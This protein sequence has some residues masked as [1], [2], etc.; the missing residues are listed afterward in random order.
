MRLSSDLCGPKPKRRWFLHKGH[1]FH[2]PGSFLDNLAAGVH[3]WNMSQNVSPD[4]T[5]DER[6][7]AKSARIA[8]KLGPGG[9]Y[10]NARAAGMSKAEATEKFPLQK[11]HKPHRL[12]PAVSLSDEVQAAR[13]AGKS[14]E[15]IHA[16]ACKLFPVEMKVEAQIE[17]GE[18]DDLTGRA[19]KDVITEI[20][21]RQLWKT[22]RRPAEVPA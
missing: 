1:P 8:A 7:A 14:R 19:P 3:L 6:R 17:A 12:P 16:M 22:Q 9:H 20:S 11:P 18:E 2:H 10:L 21:P 13:V 15:E 4:A 5:L